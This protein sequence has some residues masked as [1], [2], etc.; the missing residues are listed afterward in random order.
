MGRRILINIYN[1]KNKVRKEIYSEM[2]KKGKQKSS[3]RLCDKVIVRKRMEN[4][5]HHHVQKLR[6]FCKT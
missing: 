5:C 2:L 3:T 4:K 1:R 6:A